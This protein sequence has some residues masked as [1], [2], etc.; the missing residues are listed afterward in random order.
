VVEQARRDAPNET[1]GLIGG[2]DGIASGIYP[3]DNVDDQPRV[4]YMAEPHQ[5]LHAMREIEETRG[6][7]VLAIYHSHPASPAFPS[8]TD[9]ER[10]FYPEAVY[11][12]VSLMNWEMTQVRGFR[13]Q[14]A[15]VAEETL[16]IVEEDDHE[17]A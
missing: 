14:D 1:C 17:Q 7:E 5:L 15:R 12:I 2:R 4:R 13:I 6:E 11:I 3:L 16:E 8:P 10:A 9:V